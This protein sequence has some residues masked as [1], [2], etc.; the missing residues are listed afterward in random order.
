MIITTGYHVIATAR[1]VEIIEHLQQLGMTVYPLDVTSDESVVTLKSQVA[2]LTGGKLDYL[3][4]NAG[5]NY[6]VPGLDV[7]ISEVQFTFETNVVGVIRMCKAFAPLVIEAK[8]CIVQ[9]GSVAAV[10]YVP[11]IL[12]FL[13]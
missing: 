8:G 5:R 12:C 13:W 3:V 1:K 6:T 11:F 10:V 9:I 4:N 2:A 7:D